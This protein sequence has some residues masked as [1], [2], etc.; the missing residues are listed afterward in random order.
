M[1][2]KPRNH[3][4]GLAYFSV[5]GARWSHS[6]H[7]TPQKITESDY[8]YICLMS[9]RPKNLH[10]SEITWSAWKLANIS[11]GI[12]DVNA[13]FFFGDGATSE[14]G[15]VTR[16]FSHSPL[17]AN[18]I[19]PASAGYWCGWSV[20]VC[21]SIASVKDAKHVS[22]TSA[23]KQLKQSVHVILEATWKDLDNWYLTWSLPKDRL[24]LFLLS[25][26]SKTFY[27]DNKSGNCCKLTFDCVSTQGL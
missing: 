6:N 26:H 24:L 12:L 7:A 13:M 9:F 2:L 21:S 20:E 10:W 18:E 1:K 14:S 11:V 27:P 4:F 16:E 17:A 22:Y 15:A 3:V 19:F 25:S 8:K 5:L 23:T